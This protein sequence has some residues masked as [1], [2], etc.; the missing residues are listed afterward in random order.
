MLSAESCTAD[1]RG[2]GEKESVLILRQLPN[3]YP[4][5]A[6]RTCPCTEEIMRLK[7]TGLGLITIVILLPD[8]I[9]WR[10]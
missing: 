7:T 9:D 1:Y 3:G 4:G 8:Q 2:T 6:G 10:R 5:M